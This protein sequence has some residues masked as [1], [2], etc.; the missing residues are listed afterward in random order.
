MRAT[1]IALSLSLMVAAG[2]ATPPAD[3][4]AAATAP[5]T[6][7]TQV[8][9]RETPIGSAISVMRC[10]SA[11][12]AAAERSNARATAEDVGRARSGSGSPSGN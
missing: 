10:R 3:P 5:A 11:E 1:T 7:S 2:C 12:Q 6:A 8:C 4:A 9:T